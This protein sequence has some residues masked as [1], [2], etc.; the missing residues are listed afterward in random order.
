MEGLVEVAQYNTIIEAEM[1]KGR[2]EAY[3]IDAVLTDQALARIYPGATHTF[4]SIRL[5]V[6]AEDAAL[7]EEMLKPLEDD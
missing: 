1:A 5:L 2:L 7:A 4:A 3:G 6:K